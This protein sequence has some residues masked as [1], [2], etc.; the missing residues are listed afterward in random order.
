MVFTQN[1]QLA[2]D[3]LHHDEERAKGGDK[4]E[5]PKGNDLGRDRLLSLGLHHGGDVV[6]Q[7]RVRRHCC[8]YL[9]LDGCNIRIAVV[10]LESVLGPSLG[11]QKRR[12]E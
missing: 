3:D 7:E 10:E 4:T 8:A 11:A 2:G 5:Y 1:L 6:Q 9:T 12:A